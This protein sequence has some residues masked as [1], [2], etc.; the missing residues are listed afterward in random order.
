MYPNPYPT[1]PIIQ[2]K[3][4]EKKSKKKISHLPLPLNEA[5]DSCALL[6]EFGGVHLPIFFGSIHDKR[7]WCLSFL[8]CLEIC[9]NTT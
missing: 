7:L 6:A 4:K 5:D 1:D 9:R 3:L 2:K 8:A